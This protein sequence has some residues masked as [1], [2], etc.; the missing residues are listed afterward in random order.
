MGG[1][2]G[3]GGAGMGR[4][5]RVGGRVGGKAGRGTCSACESGQFD[6]REAA[7]CSSSG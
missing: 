3:Q 4:G 5:Q 6:S 7:C 2:Q 1:G